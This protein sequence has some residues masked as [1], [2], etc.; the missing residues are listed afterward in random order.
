MFGSFFKKTPK[1]KQTTTDVTFQNTVCNVPWN[2][3][4]QE[5]DCSVSSWDEIEDCVLGMFA[6]ADEFVTL[7][8]GDAPYH[9]RYVQAAQTGEGIDVELGIE[10]GDHTRLVGKNC[11]QKE[12][13][14][15]IREFYQTLNVQNQEKYKPVE[16]FV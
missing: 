6:D 8:A 7:T 15:I 2:I 4:T 16:F 5:Q 10:E 13:M 11:S 9:I 3:R 14:D 12:C 1:P